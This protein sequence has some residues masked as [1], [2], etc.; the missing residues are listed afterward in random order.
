[1]LTLDN[2]ASSSGTTTG[3]KDH[4]LL[5][6]GTADNVMVFPDS[7]YDN[8]EF[9]FDSSSKTYTFTHKAIGADK[10]RYSVDFAQSWTQWMD[11]EATTTIDNSTF[12]GDK[13]RN[14]W[15]GQ[16]IIVQCTR[17]YFLSICLN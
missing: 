2:P 16:H 8:S 6:K 7:D 15:E 5:R 1:M 4:L 11:W 9:T 17:F 13:N 3:A 12:F 14:W 10:F